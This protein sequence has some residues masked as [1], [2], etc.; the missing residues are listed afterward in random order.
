MPD[1]LGG[2][3]GGT[4]QGRAVITATSW[5]F[6]SVDAALT[7]AA[8]MFWPILAFRAGFTK[9]AMLAIWWVTWVAMLAS[10]AA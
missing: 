7:I 5:A 6:S 8:S 9:T 3:G 2:G 4:A 10:R 1:E